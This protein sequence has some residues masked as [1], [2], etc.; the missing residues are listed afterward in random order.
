[1]NEDREKK[2]SQLTGNEKISMS[3]SLL[4]LLANTEQQYISKLKTISQAFPNSIMKDGALLNEISKEE[5]NAI[6]GIYRVLLEHHQDLLQHLAS[7]QSAS[8]TFNDSE[9]RTLFSTYHMFITAFR[10]AEETLYNCRKRSRVFAKKIKS[11]EADNGGAELTDM[12]CLPLLRVSEY[13]AALES[14]ATQSSPPLPSTESRELRMTAK[15]LGELGAALTREEGAY[16]VRCALRSVNGCPEWLAGGKCGGRK[17]VSQAGITTNQGQGEAFLFSDTLLVT[18]R[19]LGLNLM[20]TFGKK[21]YNYV[22][23][24]KLRNIEIKG[25]KDDTV[26]GIRNGIEVTD[27]SPPGGS[28]LDASGSGAPG[29]SSS[30]S[31]GPALG[32]SLGGAAGAAG[33][34]GAAGSG[35]MYLGFESD[36][37]R[38]EIVDK[39]YALRTELEAS[40]VFGV[41]LETLMGSGNERGREV[42]HILEDTINDLDAR[43]L[44]H[45]GI[46]RISGGKRE[47]EEI[48][49]ALDSGCP[50]DFS[51]YTVHTVAGSLKLWLRSLPE[52]LLTSALSDEF[53][54]ATR[55]RSPADG[56]RRLEALIAR[57]PRTNRACL[58]RLI[59]L[60]ARVAE[61]SAENKMKSSN[62]S[63]VFS[64][65]LL[66][67]G[68][69]DSSP[70][71]AMFSFANASYDTVT[72]M[73]DH[74]KEL[75]SE[76][77][78]KPLPVT[79]QRRFAQMA[80]SP[81]HTP[82]FNISDDFDEADGSGLG[83]GGDA[84]LMGDGCGA[85][86]MGD[87]GGEVTLSL[88]DIVKQGPL[89]KAREKWGTSTYEQR[90]IIVKKGWLYNFHSQKDKKGDIYSLSGAGVREVQG[91][92][93]S[94]ILSL[95]ASGEEI[96]FTTKNTEDL[97]SWLI[98][99]NTCIL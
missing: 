69:H 68:A 21:K 65:P 29:I 46:F 24:F 39:I 76:N 88:R 95:P 85:A 86:G 55:G 59:L 64:P 54:S 60:L 96:N 32:A 90:W 12:M 91:K 56:V 20:S 19:A 22:N 15:S 18:R 47:L 37:A 53:A 27:T 81:G 50:V 25:I 33:V 78:S 94:F 5:L 83:P 67:G 8:A 48:R 1:M 9:L 77:V 34:A 2:V 57:L 73:I 72:F 49:D 61:N 51:E 6:F 63:I 45:E 3:N 23:S 26:P 52:P 98:A 40:R 14:I 80:Y 36:D 79:P 10:T 87:G 4:Q 84:S 38:R 7:T 11:L 70:D 66:H 41:P 92:P 42:P 97:T 62:L 75:F 74:C 93:F 30:G 28:G 31:G 58:T 16:H 13:T 99:I 35:T 71:A 44:V 89:Q 82:E 17:L 43:G